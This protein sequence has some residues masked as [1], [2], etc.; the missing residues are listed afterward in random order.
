MP[1]HS[2]LAGLL[3]ATSAGSH[4]HT[5]NTLAIGNTGS[6]HSH[7]AGNYDG[8]GINNYV[9]DNSSGPIAQYQ[10]LVA[11]GQAANNR[12]KA[13]ASADSAHIHNITGA[14]QTTGD[15]THTVSGSTATE[16]GGGEHNNMQ[17]YI[18]TNYIIKT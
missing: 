11:D 3:A 10:G 14:L 8:G 9:V 7:D 13:T 17:P 15:H 18:L 5:L 6:T 12:I 16:G 2:H 1:S 4:V